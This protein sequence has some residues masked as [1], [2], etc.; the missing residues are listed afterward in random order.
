MLIIG[1]YVAEYQK[2]FILDNATIELMTTHMINELTTGAIDCPDIKCGFIGEVG[3]GF[4]LHGDKISYRYKCLQMHIYKLF[5]F[6]K[7]IYCGKCFCPRT[8]TSSCWISSRFIF[9][10]YTSLHVI[11]LFIFFFTGPHSESPIEIMRIFTEAGGDAT[12]ASVGH[13]SSNYQN[14]TFL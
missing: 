9:W 2:Q 4:P 7:E 12:K 5:R 13:M 6:W 10:E 14:L 8:N 3:C 11:W 1:Y